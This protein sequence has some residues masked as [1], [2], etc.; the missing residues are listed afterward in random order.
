MNFDS[1][2]WDDPNLFGAYLNPR[3]ISHIG[4]DKANR[5]I[6][7]IRLCNYFPS[8]TPEELLRKHAFSF[9]NWLIKTQFKPGVEQYM[10]IADLTGSS[11]DNI[12]F[13]QAMT[14]VKGLM[15]Y[16]PQYSYKM[17]VINGGFMVK[18]LY[19]AIKP[20]LKERHKK[21]L[22]FCNS[23]DNEAYNLLKAEMEDDFIPVHLGGKFV[24]Y[25]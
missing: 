15:S 9:L 20:I 4:F 24:D 22:V 21:K 5:P 25:K 23:D 13:S 17:I 6:V 18:M 1:Y 8:K 14:G 7:L 3:V 10:I 11:K 16:Y 12:S 2:K 19:N